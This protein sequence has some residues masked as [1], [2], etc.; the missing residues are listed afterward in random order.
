VGRGGRTVVSVDGGAT[1]QPAGRGIDVPMP[2]MVELF[3]A[4]PDDTVLAICSPEVP[5]VGTSCCH[6]GPK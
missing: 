4:A 3:V 2:D 1:W 6:D 5:S